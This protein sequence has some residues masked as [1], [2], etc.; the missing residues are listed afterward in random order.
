VIAARADPPDARDTKAGQGLPSQH[1]GWAGI[2]PPAL[3]L[4]ASASSDDVIVSRRAS[5]AN[6]I[7]KNVR[8]G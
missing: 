5:Q 3:E 7:R 4:I 1:G 2:D 6:R 8:S